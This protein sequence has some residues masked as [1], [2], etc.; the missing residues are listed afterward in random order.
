MANFI[1][2]QITVTVRSRIDFATSSKVALPR[3]IVKL[4]LTSLGSNLRMGVNLEPN[5]GNSLLM[6][7]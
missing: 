3:M 4:P 2:G 6:S 1:I 5:F 7:R